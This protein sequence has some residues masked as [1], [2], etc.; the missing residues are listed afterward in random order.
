MLDLSERSLGLE[1]LRQRLSRLNHISQY[2]SE[3]KVAVRKYG[4]ELVVEHSDDGCSLW[5]PE[6]SDE[7]VLYLEHSNREKDTVVITDYDI[8]VAK[9]IR[10]PYMVNGIFNLYNLSLDEVISR[11]PG[12]I[13]CGHF[14]Y[15]GEFDS[16]KTKTI[17]TLG[18]LRN[19]LTD[20]ACF[21]FTHCDNFRNNI[22]YR[23]KWGVALY[24][25]LVDRFNTSHLAWLSPREALAKDV[26]SINKILWFNPTVLSWASAL[27]THGNRYHIE[28][29]ASIKYRQSQT[30]GNTYMNKSVLSFERRP[31]DINKSIDSLLDKQTQTIN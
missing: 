5:N 30:V 10:T 16:P 13:S 18:N 12:P 31:V 17:K 19:R 7:V 24:D 9:N 26:G 1:N 27:L 15:M 14:D 28:V 6:Y 8:D 21:A 2:T 29:L 20:R 3:Y 22:D 25:T 4:V 11:A 23:T